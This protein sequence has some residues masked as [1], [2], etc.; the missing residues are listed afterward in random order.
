MSSLKSRS[1]PVAAPHRIVL[2]GLPIDSFIPQHLNDYLIDRSLAG[3]GGY[4]M[5]P[6]LDNLR[7][8]T[9]SSELFA[10]AME[11]DIRV[12]DGMPL[13]LA[14]RIQ[15]TPLPARVPGSDLIMTLAEEMAKHDLRLFLLG[16]NPGTA[17]RAAAVLRDRANGLIIAG[18]HCP[19]QG[20]EDSPDEIEKLRDAIKEAHPDFVYIGLPFPKA[21]ALAARLRTDF[22]H[23]WFI[24]LGISFSFVCGDVRRAPR[25]MQA[26]GLEW[27]HRLLQEPQRLF[28]RYVI[29]GIP[30]VARLFASAVVQRRRL[31]AWPSPPT[32]TPA[33][34]VETR[35]T[36][37]DR[38]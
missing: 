25:W 4:V 20:F 37:G 32:S 12:A 6:N 8:L 1:Q 30:F 27:M 18:T 11:A 17:A 24:G 13:V 38:C 19:P 34:N 33:E 5:T 28:R 7:A 14:S 22:A 23:T 9:R 29:Q 35:G 26:I 3:V 2:M 15:G 21:S 36:G 10:R 31:G 16:G